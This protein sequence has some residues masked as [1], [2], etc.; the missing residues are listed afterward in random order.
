MV[1]Y[2]DC[3]EK[4]DKSYFIRYCNYPSGKLRTIYQ[5]FRNDNKEEFGSRF[6][7]IYN[8]SGSRI[9]IIWTEI[10]DFPI[11]IIA[12]DTFNMISRETIN[13]IDDMKKSEFSEYLDAY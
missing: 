10:N 8:E 4:Q 9:A 2:N 3:Y 12:W 6:L 11:Y 7:T 1:Y 5:K 13:N